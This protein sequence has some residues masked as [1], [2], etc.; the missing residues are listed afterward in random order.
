VL[1]RSGVAPAGPL[2]LVE[3]GLQP[4]GDIGQGRPWREHLSD[5]EVLQHRDVLVGDDPPAEDKDVVKTFSTKAV[6]HLGHKSQ[7]CAGQQREPDGVSILLHR[8]LDDLVGRLVQAGV[9]D[10]ETR[11]PKRPGN[12]LGS[13]VVAVETRLGDNHSVATIHER[14]MLYRHPDPGH[15]GRLR[16]HPVRKKSESGVWW[17]SPTS[18]AIVSFVPMILSIF[19]IVHEMTLHD[20]LGGVSFPWAGSNLAASVALSNGQLPYNTFLTSFPFTQPPGMTIVL[21]PFAFASHGGDASG[22][23]A[24]ARIFTALVAIFNVLMVGITARKHGAASSFVAGTLF[25]LYPLAFYATA[26]Y[27]LEVY[28]VFFCLLSFNTAFSQ[29]FMQKGGRLVTAGALIGFAIAIKPWAIVPAAALLVCAAVYWREALGRVAAG[30]AGGIIVPCIFFFVASPSAFLHDVVA[31]EI[32]TGGGTG[33]NP[34]GSRLAELLGITPPLGFQSAGSLPGLILLVIAI[35]VFV[36]ALA[37]ASGS[38][39][40][41]WV[42]FGTAIGLMGLG[43]LPGSLPLGYGYFLAA[44]G[45][46]LLGNTVGKII[47]IVSTVSVGAGDTSS[48]VAGGFTLLMIGAMLAVMAVCVPKEASFERAYFQTHANNQANFVDKAVPAGACVTSNDPEE[49][50]LAGRFDVPSG[51]ANFPDPA[52]IVQSVGTGAL[53]SNATVVADWER[54]FSDSKYFV[55]IP[56]GTP[57]P[58]SSSLQAYFLSNFTVIASD[59]GSKVYLNRNPPSLTG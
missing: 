59:G 39:P 30:I 21:L 53:P 17:A 49:L 12:H 27:T 31:S 5:T 9:N 19:V 4:V 44:F 48:T 8:S 1:E 38:T 10:F 32:S 58:W 45:A 41:D 57:I 35:L 55:E 43:F 42:I 33:S 54:L 24:A 3:S 56:L 36:A 26:S 7:V 34:G 2:A 51:C 13:S 47:S 11:V 52:G 25:A 50:I 15:Q 6:D 37:K 29:G 20:A 46:V 40:H 16:S 22:A 28:L 23:M 14:P 18:G